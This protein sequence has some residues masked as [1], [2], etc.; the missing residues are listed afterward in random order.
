MKFLK[1]LILFMMPFAL[2]AQT[3]ESLQK[4]ALGKI[5]W[6]VGEWNGIAVAQMGPGKTDSISMHESIRMNL[7]NSIIQVEG[8]GHSIKG[9][10]IQPEI[11][12]HAFAILSYDEKT[13]KYRWIAWRIP[14]GIFT[15]YNPEI[16][17]KKFSWSLET[18]QGRMRYSMV[19]NDKN[20]WHEKGEFSRDGQN[21]FEFFD[22]ILTKEK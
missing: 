14:G 15:E 17:D 16:S 12:H 13:Q 19:F 18:A 21:W 9:G 11:G 6:W 1:I 22:M 4:E 20:E 8:I 7:E 5:G 2:A 10:D 3:P